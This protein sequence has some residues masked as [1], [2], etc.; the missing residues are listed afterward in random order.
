MIQRLL[1]HLRGNAVAYVA[2][3]VALG[4]TSYAATALPRGS[5]GNRQLRNGAVTPAKLRNGA[6]TPQKLKASAFGGQ[7]RFSAQIDPLGRVVNSQPRGATTH[8]NN[9][10]TA[11]AFFGGAVA[12]H[13]T[14]PKD[15]FAMA[16]SAQSLQPGSNAPAYA[17]AQ[18]VP[19][20]AQDAHVL[21]QSTGRVQT[22]V[23]IICPSS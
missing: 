19:G 12:W 7:I 21:V 13:R 22:N 6:V 9:D 5:V 18:I 14:I 8:W 4:G 1:T 16:S 17:S 11:T 20:T 2:L 3:F 15:C 23:V 10:P